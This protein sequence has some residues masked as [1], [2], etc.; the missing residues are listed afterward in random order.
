MPKRL[1]ILLA[2]DDALV[3]LAAEDVLREAG[4]EVTL[5]RDGAEALAAAQRSGSFDLLVTDLSMAR[6]DG[7]GLV[8]RLRA[9]RPSLPVIA[10]TGFALSADD[11]EALGQGGGPLVMLRKPWSPDELK[12]AVLRLQWLATRAA[13]AEF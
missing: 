10:V 1:R 11:H 12:D 6:V 8:C 5:V 4:H 7:G 2:E 9:E 3:G 13:E